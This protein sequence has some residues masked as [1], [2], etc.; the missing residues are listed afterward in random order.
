MRL[1]FRNSSLWLV[2]WGA[3]MRWLVAGAAVI[4]TQLTS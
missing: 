2:E 1:L 3:G 4:V